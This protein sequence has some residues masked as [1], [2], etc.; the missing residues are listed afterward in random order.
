[1]TT[2]G[3]AVVV[4]GLSILGNVLGFLCQ[5][6]LAK[7]FGTGREMDA[8]FSVLS[9]P[10]IIMGI[11]P[12]V[13]TA[14][15]LPSLASLR[16]D[17][18][19]RRKLI[20]SLFGQTAILCVS[21]AVVGWF[22]SPLIVDFFFPPFSSALRAN[23]IDA[24]RLL[25]GAM[26][27]SLLVSYLSAVRNADKRFGR[28]AFIGLLPA[29]TIILSVLTLSSFLGILSIAAGLLAGTI[30]QTIVLL[31]NTFKSFKLRDSLPFFHPELRLILGR[32][33]P[34]GISLLP[35]TLPGFIAMYWAADLPVGSMSFL[36]Y[37]QGFAGFLSVAV[38][39]GI[40]VVSLPDMAEKYASGRRDDVFALYEHRLRYVFLLAAMGAV[41][42][43]VLGR[44]I[45]EIA[46]QHGK[47]SASSVQGVADVLPWYLIGAIS[48][49]CL[50]LL[51]TF[52][53]AVDNVVPLAK[54]GVAVPI[55]SFAAAGGL[56]RWL[57][58]EGIGIAYA[59]VS[60]IW[61]IAAM[62]YVP[63]RRYGLWTRSLVNY[64]AKVTIVSSAS[65]FLSLWT[66][67]N[68]LFLIPE[69]ISMIIGTVL[70][71]ASFIVLGCF[72]FSI[73]EVRVMMKWPAR[74]LIS[75]NGGK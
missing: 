29:M 58:Y 18:V 21:A 5:I 64:M 44:P 2:F 39:Y 60:M 19:K 33:T 55:V 36:S 7:T 41:V 53:Y 30:L 8:Y 23:V 56:S 45:L 15:I 6:I 46:Y 74:A 24:S 68:F 32:V 73:E 66:Q 43:I 72:V 9:I 25:W 61:L 69:W 49:A 38:G 31:P 75:G 27:V 22:L 65:V 50:N 70:L 67:S 47:F 16:T 10:A 62:F 13:F 71:V 52:Y 4:S 59:S 12:V 37:S 42:L 54:L 17:D 48:I 28:A 40:A 26:G 14:V 1:M 11:A 51:R 3:N 57:S 20:S 63:G 35:F 34:V